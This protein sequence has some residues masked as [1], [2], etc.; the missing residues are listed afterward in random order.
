[1]V[2]VAVFGFAA[3]EA[4]NG[5]QS[6]HRARHRQCRLIGTPRWRPPPTT[7]DLSRKLCK[8]RA[9]TW[10]A[11]AILTANPCGR[12]C[13][14]SCRRRAAA[15]PDM[16]A[17]VYLAGRGVQY[18]GDNYFVPVD[19]QIARDADVPI[20][21]IRIADFTHA[22][23]ATPGKGAHHYPRRGAR[24]S[25]RR[26]RV[27]ARAGACFG[28]SR[29][30]RTDRL[31]RRA[32]H[33]GRRGGRA[34]RSLRQD[35][36]RRDPTGRRGHRAGA[37]PDARFGQC[38]DARGAAAME[39]LQARR[40]ILCLRARAR[41]AARGAAAREDRA[42][43]HRQFF[44]R[45]G[46]RRRCRAG[47]DGRAIASSSRP[48][49]TPIRR[50][51]C[52]PSSRSGGKLPIGA[53]L[54]APIRPAHTGPICTPIRK[55]RTSP[56]P[57]P[58]CDAVGRVP[59]AAG[60]PAGGFADLPP[61]PPDERFYEEQPIYAFDD[62][63]PPPPPPPAA[64]C[65]CR[66]RRLARSASASAAAE[67]GV[68][69]VLG[70]ALPIAVGAVA[71]QGHGSIMTASRR[72]ARRDSSRR[73]RRR[74]SR[75]H[76]TCRAAPAG[77]RRRGR[78]SCRQRGGGEAAPAVRAARPARRA[79]AAQAA[80]GRASAQRQSAGCCGARSG[81]PGPSA[82][83]AAAP[84]AAGNPPAAP[85][86]AKRR[87]RF[88]ALAAP[89]A[90]ERA[91]RSCHAG[92]QTPAD[93]R[94]AARDSG[95]AGAPI[96]PGGKPLPTS[97]RAARRRDC[98]GRSDCAR[99]QTSARRSGRQAVADSRRA[100]RGRCAAPVAPA[101]SR[102]QPRGP[103]S[104]GAKRPPPPVQALKPA[105]PTPAINPAPKPN[106][107]AQPP[108]AAAASS[109]PPPAAH[110]PAPAAAAPAAPR[111]APAAIR[112]PRLRAA[113]ASRSRAV[114]VPRRRRS[115]RALRRRRRSCTRRRRRSST[116]RRLQ[117]RSRP[118]P[119]VVR[120]PPPVAQPQACG[121]PGLPPCPK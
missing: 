53:A 110:A 28:R 80:R 111:P 102:F 119:P 15:G 71:Y 17:F 87:S 82:E 4:S 26:S 31:Q 7:P 97:R 117:L 34:L 23:A 14:I 52:A 108:A 59:A 66:R 83:A 40:S 89:G 81:R 16:Q 60:F 18:N 3:A 91:S 99:R 57:A 6:P 41:R 43:A 25:L 20:E 88:R 90:A 9:S 105:P 44:G 68:L 103:V 36:R 77:R 37:R 33:A 106:V 104:T 120:V 121:R 32:W 11:R 5:R 46:L 64:I 48:I 118:P 2:F 75:Q 10:L 62:F 69:P 85:R 45:G 116:R 1:M 12:R 58:P 51:G 8:P 49:R 56:T 27:A 61:P 92:R 95:R 30:W 13:G 19:A 24:Q 63:G 35:A 86:P 65:L 109:G 73:S 22:L 78:R 54:S 107:A 93:P 21:A 39:R 84:P 113:P 114:R 98:A 79:G 101:A 67:I 94:C 74:P 76:Q 50:D 112:S 42:S 70:V 47:H 72:E 100:A 55:A 115:S 38:G 29:A 96:A